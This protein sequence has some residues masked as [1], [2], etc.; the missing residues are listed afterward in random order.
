L[1]PLPWVASK[2]LAAVLGLLPN[3]K[4]T[5]DQ[6]ETLRSDNIVR[7]A[8]SVRLKALVS[9]RAPSARLCRPICIATAKPVSSRRQVAHQNRLNRAVSPPVTH[10]R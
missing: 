2:V 7:L 10:G 1:V 4:L 3:P 9:A 8:S 5:M 6:V